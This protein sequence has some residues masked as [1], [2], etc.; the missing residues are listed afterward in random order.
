MYLMG[1]KE[2]KWMTPFLPGLPEMIP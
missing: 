2:T 1:E